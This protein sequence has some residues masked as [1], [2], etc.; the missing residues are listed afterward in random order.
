[1][2][3]SPFP[4]APPATPRLSPTAPPRTEPPPG[5]FRLNDL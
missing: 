2:R 5:G 1:M 4:R 3:L